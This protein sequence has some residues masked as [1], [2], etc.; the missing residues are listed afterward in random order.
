VEEAPR[1]CAPSEPPDQ[2]LST[3]PYALRGPQIEPEAAFWTICRLPCLVRIEDLAKRTDTRT[4]SAPYPTQAS[5]VKDEIDELIEL[6][7]LRDDPDA[8]TALE[9]HRNE[10][11]R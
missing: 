3:P 9:E 10:K 2:E 7:S 1:P 6:A 4:T 11:S 5:V 8:I